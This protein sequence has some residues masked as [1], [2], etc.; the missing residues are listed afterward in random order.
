MDNEKVFPID[1]KN[2]IKGLKAAYEFA[3]VNSI[4]KPLPITE[5]PEIVLRNWKIFEVDGKR[6]FYGYNVIDGEGRVSSSIEMFD[7]KTMKGITRSG[8]IYQLEGSTG[9]HGDA[10]HVL[11]M[12]LMINKFKYEDIVIVEL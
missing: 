10:E 3:V 8:R 12:W 4:W 7:K 9:Y 5:R 6:Y 11:Y 1:S 2:L